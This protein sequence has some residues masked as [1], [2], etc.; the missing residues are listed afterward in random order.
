M[1][2]AAGAPDALDAYIGS[3]IG[4]WSQVIKD[5]DVRAPE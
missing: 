1:S 3:E 5:A 2:I 4:K